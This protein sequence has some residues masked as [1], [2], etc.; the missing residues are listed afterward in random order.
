MPLRVDNHDARRR[1]QF[2]QV[3]RN[4][5]LFG[6]LGE[7]VVDL[8]LWPV[9]GCFPQPLN[10][11]VNGVARVRSWRKRL[12]KLLRETL[13][14]LNARID[15]VALLEVDVLKEVAANSS[16][17]NRIAVHLDAGNLRD[18]A[19]NRRQPLT[20]VFVDGNLKLPDDFPPMMDEVGNVFALVFARFRH[21]IAGAAHHFKTHQVQ[22]E[23][24]P[25]QQLEEQRISILPAIFEL[26]ES[27]KS[28][29]STTTS[30]TS[31]A[32]AIG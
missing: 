21:E 31:T 12:E 1:I 6:T 14:S 29:L 22:L 27:L 11:V 28:F 9:A 24:G 13:G 3:F 15:V 16:R 7:P 20:Q 4:A 18:R 2:A 5:S 10:M 26:Q 32:L 23:V 17:G 8:H 30:F 19:L 25:I